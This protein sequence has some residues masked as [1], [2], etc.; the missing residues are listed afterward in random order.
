MKKTL[1]WGVCGGLIALS[2]ICAEAT[3]VLEFGSAADTHGRIRKIGGNVTFEPGIVELKNISGDLYKAHVEISPII[4]DPLSKVSSIIGDYYAADEELSTEGFEI[5]ADIDGD[6]ILDRVFYGDLDIDNLLVLDDAGTFD[7]EI[8]VDLSN[9]HLD[10][11]AKMNAEWGGVPTLLTDLVNLGV[12]DLILNIVSQGG[13]DL[14]AAI[15]TGGLVPD[16]VLTGTAVPE[17]GVLS[18]M[19]FGALFLVRSIKKR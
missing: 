1:I 16:I 14:A 3:T 6:T 18:L 9:L 11:V 12:L 2:V 15:D 19:L 8:A 13:T 4:I 5:F 17:P 7:A 10:N